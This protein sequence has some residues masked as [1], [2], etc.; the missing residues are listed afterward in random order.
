MATRVADTL[1]RLIIDYIFLELELAVK[2]GG[3]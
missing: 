2:G 1:H 3:S